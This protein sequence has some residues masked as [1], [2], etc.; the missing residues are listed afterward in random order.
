MAFSERYCDASVGSNLNGGF[1][2]GGI[3]PV[4]ST[5]GT[6]TQGGGAGGNDRFAAAAGTPFSGCAV[7]DCV[8]VY[9]D[10][11]SAPT[12][13]VG[14]VT[15]V[16]GGGASLDLHLTRFSGT[17]P[18][19]GGSRTAVVGGPWKGPNGA[20]FFPWGFLTA[21]STNAAGLEQCVN[22]KNGTDY[23]VSFAEG[24][25]GATQSAVGPIW[26]AGYTNTPR[27]GGEATITGDITDLPYNFL[28]ISGARHS[29]KN[30][31]FN[32]NGV[33]V[34]TNANGPQMINVTGADSYWEQCR[35]T[36]SWRTGLR[37]GGTGGIV[38]ECEAAGCNVD[39]ANNFAAFVNTEECYFLRCWAHHNTK[40]SDESDCHGFI[41]SGATG[42]TSIF[43][44]C[45]SSHNGG[46][47]FRVDGNSFHAEFRNCTIA[48]NGGD[49][50]R[51]P[52]TSGGVNASL[53]LI[54]GCVISENGEWGVR[55][56]NTTNWGP[57]M[58]GNA[59]FGNADGSISGGNSSLVSGTIT[60]SADPFVDGDN[61]NFDLN[62]TS[63]GGADVRN[64]AP[65]GFLSPVTYS[66]TTTGFPDG[67]AAQHEADAGV[68]SSSYTFG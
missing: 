6:F 49:G 65:G 64:A 37:I 29:F 12:G 44:S 28:V 20:S 59:F 25:T 60:L 23:E 26:W 46:S 9:A 38:V 62:I 40:V 42:E 50:I 36:N 17:R 19:T 48:H 61:G 14:V 16:N 52:S 33:D 57:V 39:G 15:V 41:V 34:G 13:Y 1:P 27:D 56:D 32:R 4:T 53:V 58:R 5:G 47:G 67:G 43:D 18:T 21:A 3:Y 2:I 11:G 45:I 7:D 54:T 22:F 30:L 55:M 31:A 66:D 10:G 63:G 68:S 8:A 35:F 51:I 24:S